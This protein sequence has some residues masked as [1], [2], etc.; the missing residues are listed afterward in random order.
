M[1][2]PIILYE[3]D[4]VLVVNKPAGLSVHQDGRREAK[5]PVG[6]SVDAQLG[7]F[8]AKALPESSPVSSPGA[9]PGEETLA[10]WF[11]ARVPSAL[12]VGEPLTLTNGMVVKRPGIVHRLDKPTTGVI[13]L[14]KT[15]EAFL[16]LKEQFQNRKVEK[17]YRAFLWGEMKEE[18]G[19]ISLPIG[20]SQ[21][22]FRKRS[23]ERGAKE[24][25]RDAV[26]EWVLLKA[27]GGF[28]YIE[29]HPKT[30]R[31]HQLRVHFKALQHPIVSDHLY[32]PKRPQALGFERLALH[33]YFLAVTLPSG[34]KKTFEA[35]LPAD[36]LHA[37]QELER[38]V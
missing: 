14:A 30:G 33:A 4:E 19:I 10:D 5:A 24:P 34:E 20:R 35:P 38:L 28:S 26:T 31:T 21:S 13:I 36:F 25:L 2:S 15:Q 37:E 23:A 3:D 18:K 16:F 11:V 6:H 22:D 27:R 8:R 17:T 9:S 12:D 7:A 32:A 1:I 29:A